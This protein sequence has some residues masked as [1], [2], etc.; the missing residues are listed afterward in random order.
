MNLIDRYITEVGKHL[1]RKNRADI[2]AEIHS[3]L[4][5]MLDERTQ[6]K[7]AVLSESKDPADEATVLELLKEYGSP[8]EVAATYQTHQYLIG[9]HLF[10]IFEMVLRIALTVV[11]AVSLLGLGVNLAKTGF[12][13]VEFLTAVKDWFLNLL[14]S[15]VAAFGNIALVFAILE[16]TPVA[17]KF[18]EEFKEWDPKELTSE[19]DPDQV[20]PPDH[21]FTIIFTF[22]G[23]VILNLYPNLITIRFMNNGTQTSIPVFTETF[24]RFLPW[25]N[26]MGLLQ[27]GFNS[28]MLSQEDW[29][30]VTR[31]LSI[32]MDI[33][34]ATLLIVILRTPAIFGITP[35]TLTT[36]GLGASAD[37]LSRLVN[38]VPAIIVAVIILVT[39]IKVVKSALMLF[40]DRSGPPY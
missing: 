21:I 1:P 18:E 5:D 4:E 2:E 10:P 30:P 7:G 14:G 8:R 39:L 37:E 32:L 15:L 6:G 31:I 13:G 22:L 38:A 35:Q 25:I 36:L 12:I 27:V 26:I 24:F 19:P 20:D 11:A 34:Q 40:K 9:P 3:T 23:L 28:F 17:E 29:K 16:R 33:A